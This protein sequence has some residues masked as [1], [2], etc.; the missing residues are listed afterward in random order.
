MGKDEG[1]AAVWQVRYEKDDNRGTE[2]P[3]MEIL[4]DLLEHPKDM[5]G[6]WGASSYAQ[7][8]TIL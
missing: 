4:Y 1:R 7:E 6:Q 2:D 8:E 5:L 3:D